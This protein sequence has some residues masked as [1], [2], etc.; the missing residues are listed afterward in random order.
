MHPDVGSGFRS[1]AKAQYQAGNALR[2]ANSPRYAGTPVATALSGSQPRAR[3]HPTATSGG[4]PAWRN[5]RGAVNDAP[6]HHVIAE[7][8]R[9]ARTF[10][11][12]IDGQRD[13]SGAGLGPDTSLANDA[14]LYVG[15]APNGHYFCGAIDFLRIARGTSADSKTTIEELYAWEFHGP[16]LSDFTGRER[17][18]NGGQPEQLRALESSGGQVLGC[19]LAN[20]RLTAGQNPIK[21]RHDR[22][23]PQFSIMTTSLRQ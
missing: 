6:W 23:A 19:V 18:A 1:C 10:N 12:Y 22:Q 16:F 11:V 13:T 8:D 15:G 9:K 20:N 21:Q 2:T 5:G 3:D 14:D 17:P 4:G 7:A